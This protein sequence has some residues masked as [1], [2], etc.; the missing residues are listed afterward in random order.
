MVLT[1]PGDRA[2]A[3]PHAGTE[4][5]P[6]QTTHAVA[7]WYKSI[8]IQLTSWIQLLRKHSV[9]LWYGVEK[10]S[11]VLCYHWERN[12]SY[13]V[14]FHDLSLQDLFHLPLPFRILINDFWYCSNHCSSLSSEPGVQ[15]NKQLS[16]GGATGFLHNRHVEV[17]LV[18]LHNWQWLHKTRLNILPL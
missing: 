17:P 18:C 11:L 1:D 16:R 2:C 3:G 14:Q 9:I 10:W 4:G 12:I 7:T 15:H 13:W 8:P 6:F 5:K